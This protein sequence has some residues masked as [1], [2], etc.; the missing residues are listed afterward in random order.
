RSLALRC[1]A[2]EDVPA[3]SADRDRILQV[4]TNL[5]GNA[6][7]FTPEGGRIEVRAERALEGVRFSVSDTGRGISAE[8]FPNLFRPF[9]QAQ[10]GGLDGA[11][12]GLMIARGIVEAHG[13]TIRAESTPGQGSTFTFTI[14]ATS[15]PPDGERRHGP[16]ERRAAST[17]RADPPPE[18]DRREDDRLGPGA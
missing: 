4:L 16:A 14:P 12:L 6:I 10:G 7:K 13:G 9:W 11:G 5:I 2:G 17:S 8:D 15:P 1:E 18:G 3:I